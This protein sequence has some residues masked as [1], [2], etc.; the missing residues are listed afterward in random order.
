[1]DAM[2]GWKLT[3]VIFELIVDPVTGTSQ[4]HVEALLF[5][6]GR[7]GRCLWHSLSGTTDRYE[8]QRVR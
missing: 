2:M 1:M 4:C 3:V 6:S 7:T 8:G 5:P